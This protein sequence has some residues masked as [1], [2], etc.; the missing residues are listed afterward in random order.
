MTNKYNIFKFLFCVINNL[1]YTD[2]VVFIYIFSVTI[3]GRK[4]LLHDNQWIGLLLHD[5]S[6]EI[7]FTIEFLLLLNLEYIW[8]C[9]RVTF[10]Y[11]SYDH[12][13]YGLP[14]HLPKLNEN[15]WFMCFIWNMAEQSYIV[16]SKEISCLANAITSKPMNLINYYNSEKVIACKLLFMA[17]FWLCPENYAEATIS[18]HIPHSIFTSPPLFYLLP[19]THAVFLYS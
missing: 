14:P 6:L 15:E 12:T 19:L 5:H 3:F 11:E 7:R 1:I 13:W 8:H 9:L 4:Q 18:H 16:L 2:D 17:L 10:C